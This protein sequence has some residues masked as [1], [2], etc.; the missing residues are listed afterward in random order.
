MRIEALVIIIL[1]ALIFF[2]SY[3]NINRIY[4]AFLLML[5]FLAIYL[6]V[7][8]TL[9]KIR[10]IKE[11]YEVTSTHLHITRKTRFKE[12]TVKIP[13]NKIQHHKFDR[14][15][16]GGYVVSGKDR[17]PLFFKSSQDL[18]KF[19]TFLKSALKGRKK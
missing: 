18:E 5:L 14:V 19:E 10:A 13:L 12:K 16:L 6:L 15:F 9:Q 8:A 3:T 17:H 11:K 7:S 2:L 1:A 4:P